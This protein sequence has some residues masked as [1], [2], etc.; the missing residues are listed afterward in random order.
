[1][2][3]SHHMP[4]VSHDEF[5]ASHVV[6]PATADEPAA[7]H[8]EFDLPHVPATADELAPTHDD[9]DEDEPAGFQ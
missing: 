4:F 1:M 5:G 9:D 2:P 6:L 7:C 3:C 8:E